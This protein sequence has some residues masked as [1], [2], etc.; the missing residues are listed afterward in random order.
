MFALIAHHAGLCRGVSY[1]KVSGVSVQ[2]SGDRC[3]DPDE[4]SAYLTFVFCHLF[5]ETRN[6]TPGTSFSN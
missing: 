3:E 6:L 4:D 1:L 2:V 5:P